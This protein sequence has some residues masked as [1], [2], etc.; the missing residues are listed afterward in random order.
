MFGVI[1]LHHLQ[2]G[3]TFSLDESTSTGSPAPDQEMPELAPVLREMLHEQIYNVLKRNLMVGRFAPGQKLPLRGLAKSLG[4]SLMPVR[5]ALQRLESLGCL[6]S[7]G[8]RSMTV[9]LF[10]DDE[11]QD[12]CALRILLEGRAAEQAAINR[13]KAQL[14]DLN[15]FCSEIEK[16][17]AKEDLDRFLEANYKFHMTIA[18]MSGIAFIG[19]LLESLWMRMGPV[20]RQAKLQPRHLR[21]AAEFHRLAYTSIVN[22]DSEGAAAAIRD[23]VQGCYGTERDDAEDGGSELRI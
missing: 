2:D 21:K 7:N 17:V 14:A 4:T 16:A 9:P 18:T 8:N 1:T 11:L 3:E 22:G 23:D 6:S 10:S 12:I 20:V 19:D 5:D 13:D 15:R